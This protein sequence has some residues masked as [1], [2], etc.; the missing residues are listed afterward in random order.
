MF[1][2]SRPVINEV[3]QRRGVAVGLACA[4]RSRGS[5]I[6]R[7][8]NHSCKISPPAFQGLE[9]AKHHGQADVYND[10]VFRAFFQRSEDIGNL[11][12]LTMLAAEVGLDA[13]KFREALERGAYADRVRRLL[14]QAYEQM[15]ITAVP[16]FVIGRRRLSGLDPAEALAL[17]VDEELHSQPS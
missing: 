5:P 12:V 4:R 6:S 2:P 13:A 16:T 10:A 7:T 15:R 9:F 14:Q 1:V 3:T 11:D 8:V 17:V